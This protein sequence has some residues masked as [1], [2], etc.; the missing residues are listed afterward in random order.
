MAAYSE[1]IKNFEK[2]RDYVRDFYI[3]GFRTRDAYDTGSKRTYDNERRRIES[4]LS[5]CTHTEHIGHK[6]KVSVKID[7]RHIYENP[8]YR[9][10][11]A[12]SYTDKDIVLHFLLLDILDGEAMTVSEITDKMA[13]DYGMI[14]DTQIV[15]IKLKEYVEEGL[16]EEKKC[17]N[18]AF[19]TKSGIYADKLLERFPAAADAIAFFSE[20]IPFG[21]AGNFLLHKAGCVNRSFIR[22]H[23]HMAHTL[24]DTVLLPILDAIE[25]KHGITLSCIG[26]RSRRMYTI[27]GVPLKIRI[28]VRTGRSYVILYSARQ[29]RL[30]SLRLDGI[31]RVMRTFPCQ[32]FDTYYAY[33]ARNVKYL[34]GTSFG[35]ERRFGQPEHIHMEIEVGAGEDFIVTRL[36]REGRNGTVAKIEEGRYAF[37]ADVFDANEVLPWIKTFIGRISAFACSDKEVEAVFARDVERLHAMYG[38]ECNEAFF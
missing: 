9:C 38:G 25:H 29:K 31:K 11:T 26:L 8:L 21:I 20:E 1:L 32:E 15:R 28:S 36:M 16:A 6:K 13:A 2:I 19:F 12:K 17:G 7:G 24:D 34:W 27:T 14:F 4:W 30:L 3:F 10:Y 23:T 5:G 37:D 18:T 33:Y 35:G 22:K